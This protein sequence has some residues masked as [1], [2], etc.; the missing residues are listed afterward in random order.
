MGEV[1]LVTGMAGAGR[2][3]CLKILEDLDFEAVDNLPVNLLAR[4]LRG[5]EPGPERLAI[6]IDCRTRGFSPQ[7]LLDALAELRGSAGAAPRLLFLEC[8]D[9]VLR[10]R[11]SESRRR[12]PLAEIPAVADAVAVERGL[13][14]PL[15]AVADSVI[16]TSELS[17]SDL[18]R[19]LAGWF[20]GA[21]QLS[22]AV[23][24]FA[25]RY[26]LPREADLVFDV[27]FLRNPHY[28]QALRPHTGLDMPVQSY[29]RG[30]PGFE[31]FVESL[32]A[33]LLPLL[34]RYLQEG[35]SYLTIA[36]GCTGG[37]HRSVFLAEL[38]G[39]W[40]RERGWNAATLHRELARG[41][42]A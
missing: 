16:D 23:V 36:F 40:L 6:G 22:L 24:S 4:L 41:L 42:H 33:F 1:V 2:S 28:Q 7:M 27:R 30:D 39:A 18:R 5:D 31:G 38:M 8:D 20:G 15:K 9:E 26:G 3:T 32:Q 37:K 13:M 11:F 17:P 34:P 10:R 12:H 25:Y 21:T 35:K 14:A 29:V 19:I